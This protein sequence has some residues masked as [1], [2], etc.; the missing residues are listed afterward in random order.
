MHIDPITVLDGA[1]STLLAIQYNL[2]TGTLGQYAAT[3]RPNLVSLVK[4][5]L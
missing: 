3:T 2:V 4:D 5:I 1:T